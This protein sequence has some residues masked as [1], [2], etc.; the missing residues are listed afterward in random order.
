MEEERRKFEDQQKAFGGFKMKIDRPAEPSRSLYYAIVG[1]KAVL[2]FLALVLVAGGIVL[3]MRK[4]F[5]K[6]IVMAAPVLML[7]LELLGFAVCLFLSDWTFIA[8]HNSDFF[9]NM[10]FSLVVGGTIVFL[11][12][13]RDVSNALT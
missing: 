3:L 13:N 4:S 7:L 2:M 1:V 6:Y 12:L 9:I 11:L 5:G 10:F 8:S